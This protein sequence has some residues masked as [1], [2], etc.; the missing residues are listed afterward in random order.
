[1]KKSI[2]FL[3]ALVIAGAAVLSLSFDNNSRLFSAERENAQGMLYETTTGGKHKA[4]IELCPDGVHSY[5]TCEAG[6]AA[7]I[8]VTCPPEE[9]EAGL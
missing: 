5:T 3:P 8:V 7:C 9:T 6:S 1:M 2:R 4:V